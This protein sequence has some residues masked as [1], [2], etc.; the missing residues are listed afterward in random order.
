M[1][2]SLS[3][4]ATA[5]SAN[6]P[7]SFLAVGGSRPYTFSVLTGG[8][9]GTINPSTGQYVAPSSLNSD[10]AKSY[11]TIHVIDASA[12]TA[13]AT[14]L[15]G[16]A[17]LLFCD[18][19]QNQ[20]GLDNNHCY[21]WDQ[22]INQPKDY[23][24]YIAISVSHCKPFGN[25]NQSGGTIQ[26]KF[27]NMWALLDID[28][29]SRG[30]AARDRKEEVILALNSQYAQQQQTLNGFKVGTLPTGFVNLSNIDGAAIPYRFKISVAMQYAY[31]KTQAA[32]Y[33]DTFS[34]VQA[35]TND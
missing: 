10:P 20:M 21:L 7:A 1:A 5:V 23:S 6:A 30:P 8:A 16:N 28:I 25:I 18:I 27:V 2:I 24:I 4:S 15:V 34:N 26:N 35:Y 22:K 31:Q 32:Q 17:L 14:I 9:G 29:I 19:I 13:N 33:Y 11:D 3:Q 12:A